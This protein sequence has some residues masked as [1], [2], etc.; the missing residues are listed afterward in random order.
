MKTRYRIYRRNGGVFYLVDKISGKRESLQTTNRNEAER[1]CN[2]RNEATRQPAVNLQI[3]RAYLNASDEL[4]SK[5]TWQH[6]MDEAGKTKKGNTRERWLRAVKEKPFD[7]IRD[8]KLIETHAEH[9]IAALESG[10]VSSNMFLR[11]LHNFALDMDWIPKAIIPRRQ[12]P[13]IE[14]ED[15]RAITLEEYQ[16]PHPQKL[17]S[18]SRATSFVQGSC[19]RLM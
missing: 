8:R 17:T 4:F 18:R 2:A 1:V 5:R 16:K 6:V 11:R 9:F 12:W 3:A 10:T 15:K 14:F 7:L 19:L 13:K